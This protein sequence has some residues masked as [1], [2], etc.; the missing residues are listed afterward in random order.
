MAKS[1]ETRRGAKS[2]RREHRANVTVAFSLQTAS[3]P[4]DLTKCVIVL[5]NALD[6]SWVRET[7]AKLIGQLPTNSKA[8][9]SSNVSSVA[10]RIYMLDKALK[11]GAQIDD[12]TGQIR[13]R[14]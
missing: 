3:G 10:I 7:S 2:E 9:Q 6:S 13:Q 8:I 14:W 11:Y 1:E 12:N 4:T 5:E